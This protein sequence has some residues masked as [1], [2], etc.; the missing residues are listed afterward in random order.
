MLASVDSMPGYTVLFMSLSV[1]PEGEA[2]GFLIGELQ[3]RMRETG[4]ESRLL[5]LLD[6]SRFRERFSELPEF[7]R[8]LEERRSAW[9]ELANT[10]GLQIGYFNSDDSESAEQLAR[11]GDQLVWSPND[12]R[13]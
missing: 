1:T 5:V 7:A 3:K 9:D 10:F 2:H 6:E 11:A 13:A 4:D 8:R 12:G